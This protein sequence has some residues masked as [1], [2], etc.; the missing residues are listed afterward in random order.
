VDDEA[1]NVGVDADTDARLT[2]CLFG[3]H[4]G[5]RVFLCAGEL[6]AGELWVRVSFV[7]VGWSVGLCG[8]RG[9]A[10]GCEKDDGGGRLVGR[11]RTLLPLFCS[12]CFLRFFSR[13]LSRWLPRAIFSGYSRIEVGRERL[14][15]RS[16]GVFRCGCVDCVRAFG[17]GALAE[18]E[19]GGGG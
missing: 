17:G 3:A 6:G 5:G 9:N 18:L 1:G 16:S 10:H 14:L 12:A 8:A 15:R 13:A 11:R 4:N 19:M 2:C 7:F